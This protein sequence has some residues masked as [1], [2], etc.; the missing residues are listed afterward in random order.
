MT[1][2]TGGSATSDE[3]S[4]WQRTQDFMTRNVLPI[5]FVIIL[6]WAL[7][8]PLPG[9]RVSKPQVEDF[10]VVS[11]INVLVIFV[12]SGLTLKTDDIS[13]S[14]AW[15]GFVYGVFSI[16]VLTACVGFL[17]V[18]IPFDRPEFSY[19]LAVFCVVPTTLTSGVTLVMQVLMRRA[20]TVSVG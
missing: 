18:E 16:L 10:R 1:N 14:S 20:A 12:I 7:L 9:E 8:W 15:V 2:A 4:R 6:I 11:T 5:G 3:K 13:H 17:T 19:G